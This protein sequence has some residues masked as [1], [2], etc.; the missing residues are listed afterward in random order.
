M[1]RAAGSQVHRDANC[2]ASGRDLVTRLHR[3]RM[4]AFPRLDRHVEV[5]RGVGN[6]GKNR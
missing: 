3:Q 6:L 4:S 2:R 5:A 1:A